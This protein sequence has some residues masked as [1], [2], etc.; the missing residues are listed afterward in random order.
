[1]GFR[2]DS[3]AWAERFRWGGIDHGDGRARLKKPEGGGFVIDPRGFQDPVNLTQ[4]GDFL[5]TPPVAQFG[6]AVWGLGSGVW[7][8]GYG[9]GATLIPIG[10]KQTD[11][12]L[13]LCD[14]DTECL[15]ETSPGFRAP[16]PPLALCIQGL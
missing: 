4:I 9:L 6:E 11:I 2:A 15:H 3:Q 10:P 14:I 5:P 8:L 16:A 1:M 13:I 12:P 7:G